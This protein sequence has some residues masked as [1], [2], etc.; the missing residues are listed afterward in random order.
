MRS[1]WRWVMIV[2]IALGL[3]ACGGGGDGA[4]ND[5]EPTAVEARASVQDGTLIINESKKSE[6]VQ[7]DGSAEKPALLLT[8]SLAKDLKKGK[9]FHI[10]AG[11]DSRFPLGFSARVNTVDSSAKGNTKVEFEDVNLSD[12]IKTLRQPHAVS[13]LNSA[14]VVGV[15][16]PSTVHGKLSKNISV[17]SRNYKSFLN[18][19]VVY[20]SS[21]NKKS[22]K[23]PNIEVKTDKVLLNLEIDLGK[24]VSDSSK[25]K[26]YKGVKAEGKI[27]LTGSIYDIIY[28]GTYDFGFERTKPY[29]SMKSKL[30]ARLKAKLKIKGNAKLTLG[31]YNRAWNE[32]KDEAFKKYFI[33]VNFKGL[34]STDKVGKYPL[35]GIVY[36]SPTPVVY[37]AKTQTPLR[38]AKIGG[39]I[40]WVYIDAKGELSVN[41]EMGMAT[42]ADFELGIDKPKSGKF[43]MNKSI[44]NIAGERLLEAPFIDGEVVLKSQIGISAD[45]DAFIAGIRVAN[46]GINSLVEGVLTYDTYGKASYGVDNIGDDWSWGGGRICQEGKFGAGLKFDG[47]ANLQVNNSH[48]IDHASFSFPT[49]SRINATKKGWVGTWYV[50]DT[51][52]KCF[53][54]KPP[55]VKVTTSKKSDGKWNIDLIVT[56]EEND[57]ITYTITQQPQHGTLSGEP[58]HLVYTSDSGYSGADSIVMVVYDGYDS[59]VTTIKVGKQSTNKLPHA[60]A[61]VD[62]SVDEN[63]TVVLDGSSSTDED[64]EIVSYVWREGGIDVG[65]GKSIMLDNVPKG[66]HIY[67]LTVTDNNGSTDS[68]SIVVRVIAH[69][70][71][72]ILKKTGEKRCYDENVSKIIDCSNSYAL[73]SDGYYQAGKTPRYTR[74]DDNQVVLDDITGL[75]WQ[76]DNLTNAYEMHY[77]YKDNRFI[78]RV[79]EAQKYCSTLDIGGYENWR[80]PTIKEWYSLME[81]SRYYGCVNNSSGCIDMTISTNPI[82]KHLGHPVSMGDGEINNFAYASSSTY[83]YNITDYDSD[84]TTYYHLVYTIFTGGGGYIDIRDNY[85]PNVACVRTHNESQHNNYF[86]HNMVRNESGIV[87]DKKTGLEW[88][89]YYFDLGKKELNWT[90]AIKYCEN[91]D[92]DGKNWRLPNKYELM[93]IMEYDDANDHNKTN[94]TFIKN[95]SKLYFSSSTSY[96]FNYLIAPE[97]ILISNYGVTTYKRLTSS[98]KYGVRCVRDINK[99]E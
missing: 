54:N 35:I 76:D 88:Q 24:F 49:E 93:S 26:P 13:P 48:V 31:S 28:T 34:E 30:K 33:N 91:L 64:G 94:Q 97:I 37:T 3:S 2:V 11:I 8:D 5:N 45:L 60:N 86:L 51:N 15:I 63:E 56:D 96:L 29:L 1:V 58:P 77:D 98:S 53:N 25:F 83:D 89:D 92:L 38:E 4:I 47:A 36:Q 52:K 85:Y 23:D 39:F 19:G 74:D 57:T 17:S 78:Y 65:R 95:N 44:K 46:M 55:K 84:T 71:S 59:N 42:Y 66:V 7:I 32:V 43:S 79:K 62:F 9:L 80:L 27:Y 70:G 14:Q 67:S 50:V 82:F 90:D 99:N 81:D 6:I 69:V 18:G 20:I 61:G 40:L 72:M 10:P 21:K 73:K 75:M 16:T 22:S 68:D 87:I 41:G 12:V